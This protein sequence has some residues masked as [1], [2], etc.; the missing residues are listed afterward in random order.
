MQ[1]EYA[2]TAQTIRYLQQRIGENR[3]K[4]MRRVARLER[5]K[6]L[7]AKSNEEYA[8]L[9]S[10]LN[11]ARAH[12]HSG[13]L[14]GRDRVTLKN[15]DAT[16]AW[17]GIQ[18]AFTTQFADEGLVSQQLYKAMCSILPELSESTMRS[19]LHRLKKRNALI[20]IGSRWFLKAGPEELRKERSTP[21]HARPQLNNHREGQ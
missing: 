8:R 15:S 21:A 18:N 2:K 1:N 19:H 9:Q 5:E 20:K 7:I 16:R 13:V 11:D 10:V 4:H 14:P 6:E 12:R 3:R 17:L